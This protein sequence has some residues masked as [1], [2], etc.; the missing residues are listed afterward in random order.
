MVNYLIKKAKAFSDPKQELMRKVFKYII[1]NNI[2]KLKN[3]I[4]NIKKL[5]IDFWNFPLPSF[6]WFTKEKN[7][8]FTKRVG[9]IKRKVEF[10]TPLMWFI[11]CNSSYYSD[12][13][14]EIFNLLIANGADITFKNADFRNITPLMYVAEC[15][16]RD[17]PYTKQKGD[18]TVKSSLEAIFFEITRTGKDIDEILN[19]GDNYGITAIFYFIKAIYD[20][21]LSENVEI[22]ENFNESLITFRS[23]N[24][25]KLII[26]FS[27]AKN[28]EILVDKFCRL[29]TSNPDYAF[30]D[31]KT[32]PRVIPIMVAPILYAMV[33]QLGIL[34]DIKSRYAGRQSLREP[35]E[36][37]YDITTKAIKKII[38]IIFKI[39]EDSYLLDSSL[40]LSEEEKKEKIKKIMN[41]RYNSK[42]NED[43]DTI[44]EVPL[45][46]TL[47]I[48]M[49][50][51]NDFDL[52]FFTENEEFLKEYF[53]VSVKNDEGFNALHYYNRHKYYPFQTEYPLDQMDRLQMFLRPQPVSTTGTAVDADTVE[54][55]TTKNPDGSNES[56]HV[57][58]GG[59][60]SKRVRKIRKKSQNKKKKQKKSQKK[61][62]KRRK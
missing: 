57:K 30:R 27:K 26:E 32:T 4:N 61:Q 51:K 10:H 62:T 40:S 39:I 17:E 33:K 21:V 16:I 44:R 47:L 49:T 54:F 56:F 60:Q 50:K 2:E 11:Y 19:A 37:K 13:N 45:D 1:I 42:A 23:I 7:V 53:D 9:Y 55:I 20:D 18:G 24:N 41:D 34:S 15:D 14:L 52:E 48:Y 8:D 36:K 5:G 25:L 59:K 22:L 6:I 31:S 46:D 38:K 12:F 35:E 29:D 28:V 43:G 3:F 58:V